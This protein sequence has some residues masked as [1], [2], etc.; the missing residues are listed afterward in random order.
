MSIT[1]DK[2]VLKDADV[3]SL[4]EKIPGIKMF[5]D[6]V[7]KEE[8]KRLIAAIDGSPWNTDIK[9]RTQQYGAKYDYRTKGASRKD[10]EKQDEV[11]P[12]PLSFDFFTKR[13][14]E[15]DVYGSDHPPDQLII[16]EYIEDQGILH[17]ID[18]PKLWGPTVCTLSL[19][20]PAIMEFRK[21][22]ESASIDIILEPRSLVV[23]TG[24]ARYE[25]QHGIKKSA[26]FMWK[27]AKYLRG[28]DF[29]R[30]SITC[31]TIAFENPNS[32]SR[33]T[34]DYVSNGMGDDEP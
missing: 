1:V 29:R 24:P 31:R 22:K 30:I 20:S 8:E 33:K 14:I 13:L 18:A 17:H 26:S 2:L 25:W 6:F 11:E 9:R 5:R 4:V 3:S 34:D 27:G 10:A 28:P 15:N 19:G 16:N 32:E 21:S 12:L 7:T 23:L